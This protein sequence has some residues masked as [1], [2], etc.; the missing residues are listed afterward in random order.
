MRPG[1]LAQAARLGRWAVQGLDGLVSWGKGIQRFTEQP[2]CILRLARVRSKLFV[3]LSDGT[4]VRPSD[5]VGELHLWNKR[6]PH[7][8]PEGPDLVWAREFWRLWLH[9]LGVLAHYVGQEPG[10]GQVRAFRGETVF[11]A[12]DAFPWE[13]ALKRVGFDVSSLPPPV[14]AWG[15]F[16][17]FWEN[18]YAWA[19]IWTYNPGSLRRKDF[20]RL[21]RFRIWISREGLLSRHGSAQRA[22]RAEE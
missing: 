13:R 11:S 5:W 18:G 21:R 1:L 16:K 22:E 8:P 3:R 20:F 15:R 14:S 6:L 2:G 7:I 12:K 10:W 4:E 19:L 17:A 9:S